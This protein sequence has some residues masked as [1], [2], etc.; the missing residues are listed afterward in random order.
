MAESISNI[1]RR[2]RSKASRMAATGA[3]SPVRAATAAI[4]DTLATLDVAW[5]WRL[6]APAITSLGPIIHPTR[7]PVMA[8]VLATPLMTTLRSASS[9]TSAGIDEN[10]WSP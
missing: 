10:V 4:C 1:F 2:R 5:D 7:Q 8:N 6:A 3:M 9:G